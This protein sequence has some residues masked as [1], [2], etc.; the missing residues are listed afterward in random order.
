MPKLTLIN[1]GQGGY[2]LAR[3]G[4]KI[5]PLNLAYVAAVT[6][7]DWD[8]SVQD[9]N[10]APADVVPHADLVGITTLT[11]TATRAYELA[12]EYRR[13]GVPVVLGGIHA[14]MV[15]EEALRFAD[16]VVL[17]E[18]ESVWPSVIGDLQAGAL[19]QRYQG[20]HLE[21]ARSVRPR[22]ELL[23]DQYTIGS[24]QTS[25]GC[26]FNCEFC[27]VKAFNGARFRQRDVEDVLDELETIPQRAVFFTDD[28][29]IGYSAA[30]SDRAKAI[31]EGMLHRSMAKR[32]FC[33][34][35]INFADDDELLALAQRSGCVMV[36]VG[37]ESVD[38][39][40]LGGSMNKQLNSRKGA[41]Y[42][43]EFLRRLHRHKILTLGTMVFGSDEAGRD[44]FERTTRFY[45]RSGLDVPWPGLL[46][47][48][49]GTRLFERLAA[50]DRLLYTDFPADWDK[51]N[52]TLVFKP[53]AETPQAF[54]EHFRAFARANFTAAK[55]AARSLKTLAYS[56][57]LVRTLLTYN[58]NRSL[59]RRFELGLAPA[60]TPAG[61]H[62]EAPAA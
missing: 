60:A 32:W 1:P 56:R 42:Y 48:Y 26:P 31:F 49:P 47:P 40:V 36:L 8:V 12:G 11:S 57:S 13:R 43:T 15:P 55:V 19:K 14:S 30:S 25:R 3:Q 23:S 46:T 5:Q 6:P 17:G 41:A 34:T 51:Y 21:F 45:S 50:E 61:N 35:S 20:E 54:F 18:A 59:S 52:T 22:R 53:D 33:Q 4:F 24:I 38:D 62:G 37:I 44:I 58:F 29:L 7:D 2:R 27:S 10:V 9:E 28:N 39:A 16:A